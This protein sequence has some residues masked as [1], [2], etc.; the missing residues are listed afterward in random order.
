MTHLWALALWIGVG[1]A[2]QTLY[3]VR[4]SINLGHLATCAAFT[5]VFLVGNFIVGGASLHPFILVCAYALFA[6]L[7]AAVCKEE[8]LP[9]VTEQLLLAYT[10]I[11]WYALVVFFYRGTQVQ[12]LLLSFLALPSGLTLYVA[13]VRPP[14]RFWS[15]LSLYVWFL[16]IV[17]SLALLQFPYGSLGVLLRGRTAPSWPG[18]F[19]GIV[20][21]AALTYLVVNATYLYLLI[22]RRSHGHRSILWDEMTSLMTQRTDSRGPTHLQALI[23]V[24]ALGGALLANYAYRSLPDALAVNLG[25][26]AAAIVLGRGSFGEASGATAALPRAGSDTDSVPWEIRRGD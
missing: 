17:V 14:L 23:I 1:V 26:V 5:L 3:L 15:K 4:A 7:L 20:T 19:D 11:F 6:F 18:P 25:I 9:V 10:V 2:L 21:G 22:Q 12:K 24:A 13:F 16:A 8:I